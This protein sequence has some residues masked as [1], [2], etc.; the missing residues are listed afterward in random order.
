MSITANA[1]Q[2]K[3]TLSIIPKVGVTASTLSGDIAFHGVFNS[4]S[5]EEMG[6][7]TTKNKKNKFGVVL[8]AEFQYQY[9][10]TVGFS[11]GVLYSQQGT[12][13]KD[14]SISTS[15]LSNAKINLDYINIPILANFYVS[16]GLA[17][18]VGVQPGF[19]ISHKD[20]GNLLHNG[21]KHPIDTELN[22]IRS[23]YF[24]I[25]LAVSYEFG[26]VQVEA[27]YTLGLTDVYSSDVSYVP[28]KD[29]YRNNSLMLTVGYKF[30]L[31]L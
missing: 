19:C 3:G 13:F 18:K 12:A 29:I 16:K 26:N 20:K 31:R 30:P 17:L 25:P 9:T 4:L 15:S 27:R 5:G 2:E 14:L 11:L 6:S 24:T 28:N 8:G 21:E 23:L 1:Q 7:L 10:Y 22:D